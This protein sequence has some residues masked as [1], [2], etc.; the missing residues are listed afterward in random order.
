MVRGGAAE[1]LFAAMGA[2]Q[3]AEIAHVEGKD[4]LPELGIKGLTA[5]GAGIFFAHDITAGDIGWNGDPHGQVNGDH[6]PRHLVGSVKPIDATG[7][8]A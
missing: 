6:P 8:E 2:T 5:G 7:G 4:G 3:G 1:I